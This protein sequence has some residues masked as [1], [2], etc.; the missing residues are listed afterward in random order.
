VYFLCTVWNLFGPRSLQVGTTSGSKQDCSN[1]GFRTA[2]ISQ[3]TEGKYR[4]QNIL[5]KVYQGICIDQNTNVN[6]FKEGS[7]VP[8][9]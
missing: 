1:L 8:M 5:Q 9:E 7:K 2:Y 3:K 6:V 4:S